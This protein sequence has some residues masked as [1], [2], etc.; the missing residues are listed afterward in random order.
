MTDFAN[1]MVAM[2]ITQFWTRGSYAQDS[3][4]DEWGFIPIPI[5]PQGHEARFIMADEE[6][7]W[8]MPSSA[9]N[10]LE[11]SIIAMALSTDIHYNPDDFLI[12]EEAN[13]RN[14]ATLQMYDNISWNY[15]V[16]LDHFYGFGIHGM[17]TGGFARI[18]E[19]ESAAS[20]M[21]S[22]APNVYAN[23]NDRLHVDLAGNARRTLAQAESQLRM[24][25][26]GS[27]ITWEEVDDDYDIPHVSL[28]FTHNE[29][30]NDWTYEYTRDRI[31][32][33]WEA[34]EE[35]LAAG[36][37]EEQIQ[38]FGGFNNMRIVTEALDNM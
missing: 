30:D 20:V 32:F 10:Q 1:G 28:T 36:F 25:M 14:F 5:G 35:A 7:M 38:N 11:A 37:T 29:E 8:F 4:A 26:F 6:D 17:T 2:T 12:V 21:E 24:Q 16:R 27:M 33:A 15:N 18:G 31:A 13:V 9:Q 23:I 22:I 19:G 34:L 3:M